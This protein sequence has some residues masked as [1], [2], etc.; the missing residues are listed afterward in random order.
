MVIYKRRSTTPPKSQQSPPE[1]AAR[2]P[3]NRSKVCCDARIQT[4]Q[5]QNLMSSGSEPFAGRSGQPG[6]ACLTVSF[7]GIISD[8]SQGFVLLSVY[9][10]PVSSNQR[11]R[12]TAFPVETSS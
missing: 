6:G 9:S 8:R 7:S 2:P 1:I 10:Q 11:R 3:Q 4:S 5:H 12:A